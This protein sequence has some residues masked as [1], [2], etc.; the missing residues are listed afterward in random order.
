MKTIYS[1]II[2]VFFISMP[3]YASHNS[4]DIKPGDIHEAYKIV[5]QCQAGMKI[6]A[7][8][9]DIYRTMNTF[10]DKNELAPG[11]AKVA[12]KLKADWKTLEEL[13]IPLKV[14]LI[15]RGINTDFL[16]NDFYKKQQADILA[17]GVV[18]KSIAHLTTLMEFVNECNDIKHKVQE[19]KK[20][21]EDD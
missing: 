15:R 20:Q 1:F 11:S 10:I 2:L 17:K 13:S 8:Y 14:A 19:L 5:V 6:L 4:K 3:A 18:T 9:V 21:L 16:D 7:Y 12:E